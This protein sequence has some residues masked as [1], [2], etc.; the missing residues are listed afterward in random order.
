M[1][2][3][4]LFVLLLCL[5]EQ[6]RNVSIISEGK[7]HRNSAAL[8]YI[9][10]VTYE[11]DRWQYRKEIIFTEFSK[12]KQRELFSIRSFSTAS[13]HG[14]DFLSFTREIC[15]AIRQLL[16]FSVLLIASVSHFKF[17]PMTFPENK[18]Y[19]EATTSTVY[20]KFMPFHF[21]VAWVYFVQL[22]YSLYLLCFDFIDLFK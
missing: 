7:Q 5:E 22:I 11:R 20:K 17:C 19:G 9:L 6:K 13:E 21:A 4:N 8:I 3:K 14:F 12:E 10:Y 16:C 1:S 18:F 15:K 2:S